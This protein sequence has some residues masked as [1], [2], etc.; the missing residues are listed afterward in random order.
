[1]KKIILSI[2]IMLLIA[3]C[4]TQSFIKVK[5]LD[6]KVRSINNPANVVAAV[7]DTIVI[8]HYSSMKSL[9]HT[10]EVY[11]YYVGKLPANTYDTTHIRIFNI[12]IVLS[13]VNN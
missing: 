1:M 7:G 12:G 4:N 8:D 3:S 5:Y 9:Y 2:T 13:V 6:G 10:D 11:G